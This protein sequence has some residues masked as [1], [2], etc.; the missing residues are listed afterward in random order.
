MPSLDAITLYINGVPVTPPPYLYKYLLSL[1]YHVR[2]NK[3][4]YVALPK[5]FLFFLSAVFGARVDLLANLPL[6]RSIH[7]RRPSPL[8]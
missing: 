2:T 1:R 8:E 6:A 5:D 4:G 7:Q 3:S